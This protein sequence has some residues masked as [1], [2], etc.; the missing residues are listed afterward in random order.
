MKGYKKSTPSA[1]TVLKWSRKFE[2]GHSRVENNACIVLADRRLKFSAVAKTADVLTEHISNF[3][4][5]IRAIR[6]ADG[7]RRMCCLLIKNL[8]DCKFAALFG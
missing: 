2:S 7:C 8:F 3:L 6:K 1:P 5:K 4:M